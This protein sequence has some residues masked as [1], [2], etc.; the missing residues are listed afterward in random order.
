MLQFDGINLILNH[1]W[2]NH[3]KAVSSD[4][5]T[6]ARD[7]RRYHPGDAAGLRPSESRGDRCP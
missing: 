3:Q 1:A 2:I 6:F 7:P 5:R 4:G